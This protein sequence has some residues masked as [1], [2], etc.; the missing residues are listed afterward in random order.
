MGDAM[1][2]YKA[3]SQLRLASEAEFNLTSQLT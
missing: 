2:M 3:Y 1:N